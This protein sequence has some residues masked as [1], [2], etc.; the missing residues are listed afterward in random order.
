[1]VWAKKALEPSSVGRGFEF[2]S[3]VGVIYQDLAVFDRQRKTV[4]ILVRR[5]HPNSIIFSSGRHKSKQN[6]HF[7]HFPLSKS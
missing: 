4:F 1:M 5:L 2:E 6:D 3:N 7:N